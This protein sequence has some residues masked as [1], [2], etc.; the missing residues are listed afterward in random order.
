[1]TPVQAF[2]N[3]IPPTYIQSATTVQLNTVPITLKAMESSSV[4]NWVVQTAKTPMGKVNP[5]Q[6]MLKPTFS[7]RMRSRTEE[8]ARISQTRPNPQ[9]TRARLRQKR[10]RSSLASIF[11]QGP[12]I[13]MGFEAYGM[14]QA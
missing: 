2:I 12:V 6:P 14:E 5:H 3:V 8:V 1:M 7:L 11:R 10:A 4:P 13:R 9:I